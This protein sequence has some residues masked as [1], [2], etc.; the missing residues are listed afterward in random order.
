MTGDDKKEPIGASW[1]VRARPA[2]EAPDREV[3]DEL[4]VDE[5]L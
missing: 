3:F 1:V 5:Y 4:A 2:L